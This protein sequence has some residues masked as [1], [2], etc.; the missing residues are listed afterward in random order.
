MELK[1]AM[2]LK[3]AVEPKEAMGHLKAFELFLDFR[4]PLGRSNHSIY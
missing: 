2:E 4:A 3:E 1:G